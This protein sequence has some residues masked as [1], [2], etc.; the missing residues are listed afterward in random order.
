MRFDISV[1][2]EL[3]EGMRQ[4]K[5]I[6]GRAG[7]I[8]LPTDTVYG[9]GCDAF[10]AFAVNSL[11]EA[12]GRGRQSPPPVL[13]PS[14][15]TLRAL[16]DN[17]SEVAFT[18]A[19]K[20][21]PG[22]LTMIVRAQP[23]LSWDLGE[24]KGTV[25]LR[26]PNQDFTLALL[27]DVGP[28]AVSSANLTG[29]EPANDITAAEAFFEDKVGVY[30]DAGPAKGNIPSTIVD[31]TEDGKVKVVRLGAISVAALKKCVGKEFEVVAV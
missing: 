11:L 3:L 13:I 17:P 1:T 16:A 7:L 30:L 2:N 25:A 21:W 14:L 20:F 29:Q 6:I 15:D 28:L 8:V 9:I 5:Q 27:K 18:L 10:S 12:K 4:A 26:I 31:L 22:A 19:D 24:T 23:S